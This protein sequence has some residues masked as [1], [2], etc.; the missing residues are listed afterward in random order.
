MKF[1]ML[2]IFSISVSFASVNYEV[3][4][5]GP[6]TNTQKEKISASL[7]E[8]HLKLISE[9]FKKEVLNFTQPNGTKAFYQTSLTNEEVYKK[10]ITATWH[11]HIKF[12]SNCISSARA[13]VSNP[14]HVVN[15]NWCKI[16]NNHISKIANTLVHEQ[17]HTFSFTHDYK[18]TPLRPYSVPY[19]IGGII[20]KLSKNDLQLTPISTPVTKPISIPWYK[21]LFGWF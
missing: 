20:E 7:K 10:L 2:L 4:Y 21:K 16:A 13:F 18:P 12:Y 19:G 9:D 17:T 14:K 3:T 8:A 1:L 5:I 11:Y 6:V 15:L